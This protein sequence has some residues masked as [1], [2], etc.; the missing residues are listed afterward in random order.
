M[1][2]PDLVGFRIPGPDCGAARLPTA[3]PHHRPGWRGAHSSTSKIPAGRHTC[4]T[5]AQ[6]L[7][8]RHAFPAMS[9]HSVRHFVSHHRRKA[10]V[11]LAKSA[12][13]PCDT[14]LPPEGEGIGLLLSK[15]TNSHCAPGKL[16]RRRLRFP[17]RWTMALAAGSLEIGTSSSCRTRSAP[18]AFPALGEQV[19]LGP[20]PSPARWNIHHNQ[21]QSTPHP[22]SATLISCFGTRL[23]SLSTGPPLTRRPLQNAPLGSAIR[24]TFSIG[25]P[26]HI[27]FPIFEGRGQKT[28]QLFL[29]TCSYGN[30]G[31][32]QYQGILTVH[33]G[34]SEADVMVDVPQPSPGAVVRKIPAASGPL[35]RSF[36]P[37]GSVPVSRVTADCA[38]HRGIEGIHPEKPG[39]VRR[40]FLVR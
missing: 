19:H 17:T 29:I 30:Q 1:Q 33:G 23:E 16:R 10:G 20:A 22:S 11:I 27:P 32:G 3:R 37:Y 8:L 6:S 7:H 40:Q 4:P 38:G 18:A 24:N 9:G 35:S 34:V 28:I 36:P 13:C 21:G 31:T 25:R 39:A 2:D 14:T 12:G 15:T 5:G 26:S